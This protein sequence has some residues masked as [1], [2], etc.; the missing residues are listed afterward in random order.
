MIHIIYRDIYD[1]TWQKTFCHSS[2]EYSGTHICVDVYM[3]VCVPLYIVWYKHKHVSQSLI[4][5]MVS[6]D[7]K[8]HVYLL[9]YKHV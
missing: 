7:V 3:F 2:M 6:V 9:T 5:F 4:S 1:S 8:H